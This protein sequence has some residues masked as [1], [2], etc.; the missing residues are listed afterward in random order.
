MSK[1]I[2]IFCLILAV[3]TGTEFAGAQMV[4]TAT[5]YQTFGSSFYEQSGVQWGIKGP[6]FFANFGG[7]GVIP[8]FGNPDPNAGIRTGIGFNGGGVSGSLG[9]N[10][11][12]GSSRTMTS[13]TPSLTTM[14]GYPG[15]ISN[16]TIQPFVTGITPVIGGN[17]YG[18]PTSDNVSSQMFSSHQ[19]AQAMQMLS[20]A[21]AKASAKQIKAAEAFQR[22]LQ[23]ESDGDLRTARA[24]YRKAL[25][26]DQ[27]P[28]RQQI[29]LKM[30]ARGWK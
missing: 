10:F 17:S 1:R 22:G 5:P 8:P 14:N 18:A 4:Q 19:Q 28:L 21:Q 7:G 11:A 24:N 23:A 25:A 12:Q 26:I 15:T 16:Q 2:S 30:H 29:M 27:G 9:L 13:T 20:R 3:V 6:N